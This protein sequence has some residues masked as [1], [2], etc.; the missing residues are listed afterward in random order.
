MKSV[1]ILIAAMVVMALLIGLAFG[2]VY[3]ISEWK[4]NRNY[5]A[6]FEPLSALAGYQPRALHTKMP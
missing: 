1:R 5:E 4:L 2:L 6:P 3:G